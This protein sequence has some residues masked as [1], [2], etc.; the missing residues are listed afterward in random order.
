MHDAGLDAMF[1]L[2]LYDSI[3]VAGAVAEDGQ[4]VLIVLKASL[5]TSSSDSSIQAWT[6]SPQEGWINRKP[7]PG[8]N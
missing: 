5:Y 4:H 7:P 3:E 6:V 8:T 2:S 1:P